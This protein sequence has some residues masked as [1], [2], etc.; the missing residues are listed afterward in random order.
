MERVLTKL[1]KILKTFITCEMKVEVGEMFLFDTDI[2]TNI[3]QKKNLLQY[4]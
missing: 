2:I 1:L 3:P 4:Y